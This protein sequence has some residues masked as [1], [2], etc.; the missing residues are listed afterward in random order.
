MNLIEVEHLWKTFRI[1][2]EKRNTAFEALVG[3][4]DTKRGYEEFTALNDITFSLE[5]GEWL[6]VIGPNGSGKSTLLKIIANTI[7]PTKGRV[8]INGRITSFLELGVGFQP[9]LTAI[10]N[11]RVYGAIMGFSDREIEERVAGILDFGGLKQFED[12]KLKNFSSGMVVRLAFSTAIQTEPEILLLDE[13][14]AVGD[15]GFQQKCFDVFERYR[16]EDKTVVFVT[17]DMN[18]VKRFCDRALLLNHG[19]QVAFGDTGEVVDEYV[20]GGG[21]EAAGVPES[22]PEVEE[23]RTVKPSV[24]EGVEVTERWGNKRVVITGVEFIDK[25]GNDCTTFMSGDSMKIRLRYYAPKLV[26]EPVFGVAIYDVDGLQCFG[27]NTEL[28]NAPVESVEG[29][30]HID[31]LIEKIPMIEGK[32]LLT[33]AVHSKDNIHYD[34]WDKKYSFNVARSGRDAGLFDIPCKWNGNKT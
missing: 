1:P 16:K 14:L 12:T 17:H 30:G 8:K 15:M 32:F 34:W 24:V 6:G 28:K 19:E 21:P 2:H 13:V 31:L 20:Y 33:A 4:F 29:V 23:T 25:F 22:V 9:D 3:L 5:K 7:R 11:I 10:E 26:E 18:S 27:T